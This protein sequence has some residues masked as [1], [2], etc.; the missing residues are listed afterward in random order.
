MKKHSNLPGTF[1]FHHIFVYI[2]NNY[3]SAIV[4]CQLKNSRKVC[5]NLPGM[6]K[7]KP[8]ILEIPGRRLDARAKG[9]HSARADARLMSVSVQ[10]LHKKTTAHASMAVVSLRRSCPPFAQATGG[11]RIRDLVITNDALVPAELQ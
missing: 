3:R 5:L 10:L 9:G 7:M 4:L 8:W 11:I 1:L 6:N 2:P